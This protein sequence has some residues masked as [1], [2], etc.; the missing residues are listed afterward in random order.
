[1]SSLT[2]KYS[3]AFKLHVINEIESGRFSS[4]NE[5]SQAYGIKG[6]STVY[7]WLRSY[8]KTTL[9]NKVVRVEKAGEPR[10]IK[11][12]KERVRQLEQLVADLSMDKALEKAGLEII[13]E[14]YNEDPEVFKKKAAMN[15]FT[16]PSRPS[17]G[18]GK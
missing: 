8:G 11:R 6:G 15:E 1:M 12:L 13:C 16:G 7:N 18:A 17:P 9:L 2:M 14:R 3:E 5:A 10:E 4:P